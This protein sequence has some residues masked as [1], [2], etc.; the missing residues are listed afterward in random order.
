M[1]PS[2][3][4][5]LEDTQVSSGQCLLTSLMDMC[6]YFVVEAVPTG[7]R[8]WWYSSPSHASFT[9]LHRSFTPPPP[10]DI[11]K[12]QAWTKNSAIPGCGERYGLPPSYLLGQVHTNMSCV[13]KLVIV[14][15]VDPGTTQPWNSAWPEREGVGCFTGRNQH[16]YA[17]K[18][19]L[20]WD[21]SGPSWDEWPPCAWQREAGGLPVCFWVKLIV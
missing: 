9:L 21:S 5:S 3:D 10:C 1:R 16:L 11:I 17:G 8:S 20:T 15:T 14:Q 2:H 4:E 12:A 6:Q 18:P 13:Y 19:A 7:Q